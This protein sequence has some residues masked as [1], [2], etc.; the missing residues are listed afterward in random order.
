MSGTGVRRRFA[1][2]RLPK[3]AP[4]LWAWS[5]L[6]LAYYVLFFFVLKSLMDDPATSYWTAIALI[7]TVALLIANAS[8]NWLFFRKRNLWL[9][10]V[11][12]LP[13]ALVALALAVVLFRIRSP[14]LGWYVAYLVYLVYA[15]WWGYSVW[16][17]NRNHAWKAG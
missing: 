12:F 6:G 17:L 8:W 1:E 2:L 15:A 4:R 11:F 9:S 7:L 13:Y 3:L 14:L 5:I 16:R 10:L